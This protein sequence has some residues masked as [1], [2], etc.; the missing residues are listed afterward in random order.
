MLACLE[1]PQL[2]PKC[3]SYTSGRLTRFYDDGKAQER[4][5][6][7][8]CKIANGNG[9]MLF[10]FL[11][12]VHFLT[13][14]WPKQLP[15]WFQSQKR[16][17]LWICKSKHMDVGTTLIDGFKQSICHSPSFVQNYLLL[18][19]MQDTFISFKSSQDLIQLQHQAKC[20]VFYGIFYVRRWSSKFGNL[21]TGLLVTHTT[22]IW[23]KPRQYN[24]K[25]Y[26]HSKKEIA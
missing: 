15:G 10:N 5:Q 19:K 18:P 16:K 1:W 24:H 11:I 14:H 26:I 13:S 22:N 4:E 6:V 9:H 2:F 3:F 8:L 12:I 17:G 25:R 21:W 7:S 20:P 23:V